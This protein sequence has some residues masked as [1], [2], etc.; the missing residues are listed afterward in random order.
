[1]IFFATDM[2]DRTFSFVTFA[3]VLSGAVIEIV[4]FFLRI[5]PLDFIPAISCVL[6]GVALGQHLKLGLET[7]SDV[8]NGVNFI[9][10]NPYMAVSFAAIFGVGIIATAVSCFMP[11]NKKD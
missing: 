3:F 1:M 2:V 5:K 4:Y 11:Q 6:Y 7:L 9:G 10:G 8:W